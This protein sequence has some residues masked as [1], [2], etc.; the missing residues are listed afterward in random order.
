MSDVDN[1]GGYVGVGS[2]WESSGLPLNFAVNLKL[3]LKIKSIESKKKKIMEADIL[4]KD[5]YKIFILSPTSS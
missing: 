3:L 2:I 1:E 5:N 4:L